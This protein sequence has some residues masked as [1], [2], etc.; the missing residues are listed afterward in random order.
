MA[1]E[2]QQFQ[3]ASNSFWHYGYTEYRYPDLLFALPF[4]TT[5][6]RIVRKVK[7]YPHNPQTLGEHLLKARLDRKLTKKAAAAKMDISPGTI[8]L[9]ETN[10]CTPDVRSM[11]K[12]IEF[13]GYYPFDEPKTL[14]EKIRKHRYV[15]GLSLQEFGQILGVDGATVWTWENGKYKLLRGTI[16]KIESQIK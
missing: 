7:A 8:E 10:R 3:K 6:N 1:F 9:W 16:K 5:Q 15:H 2:K 12:V 4:S 13:I 11:K 14:S